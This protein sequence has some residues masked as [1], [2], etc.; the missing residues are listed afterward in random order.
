MGGWFYWNLSCVGVLL[1]GL[2]IFIQLTLKSTPVAFSAFGHM[3]VFH[4]FFKY[5]L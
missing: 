4:F 3:P 5:F 1:S 2:G